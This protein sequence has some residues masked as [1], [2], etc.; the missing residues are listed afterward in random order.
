M[1]LGQ[2][3]TYKQGQNNLAKN[4]TKH[5]NREYYGRLAEVEFILEYLKK[6]IKN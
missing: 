2:E 5:I 6:Y 4:L 1:I 3:K